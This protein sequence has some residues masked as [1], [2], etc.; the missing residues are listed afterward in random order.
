MNILTAEQF[1]AQGTTAGA[2]MSI[3]AHLEHRSD[4]HVPDR[5]TAAKVRTVAHEVAAITSQS[6]AIPGAATEARQRAR[7]SSGKKPAS[8]DNKR[9]GD[10]RGAA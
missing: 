8:N 1:I 4:D 6:L 9:R 7:W 10:K 5:L 2:I 3:A